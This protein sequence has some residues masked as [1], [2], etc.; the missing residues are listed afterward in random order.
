[1]EYSELKINF[2]N[3]YQTSQEIIIAELNNI[4]FEGFDEKDN[5]LTAIFKN[6][7]NIS[8]EVIDDLL[9]RHNDFIHKYS[10]TSIEQK[11]WNE[12]WEHNFKPVFID[13]Q[14]VIKA[15]FHQDFLEYKYQITIDPKMSFGTGHHETT[16]LMLSMILKNDMDRLNIADIGCGTCVLSILASLKGGKH[17]TA[18]DIDEWAYTNSIENCKKNN[19][20]NIDI[21]LGDIN[22]IK[23]K[24]FDVI[25]ANINRNVLLDHIPSYAKMLNIKG[26]LFLSGIYNSDKEIIIEKALN[27]GFEFIDFIEKNNW[28]SLSL[29]KTI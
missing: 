1:M 18:I 7:I 19:I 23:N 24:K 9:N 17:I 28:I 27:S 26:K 15:S 20:K 22:L 12:I 8:K 6:E 4:G 3:N 5:I 25:L 10:I 2:K 21:L 29:M 16:T 11:N 13:N 14:C